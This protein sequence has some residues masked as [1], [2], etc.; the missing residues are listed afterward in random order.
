MKEGVVIWWSLR[1]SPTKF[2]SP[3]MHYTKLTLQG[4]FRR[5]DSNKNKNQEPSHS[6]IQ[7]SNLINVSAITEYAV[8]I[9]AP[10]SCPMSCHAWNNP[11]IVCRNTTTITTTAS[12]THWSNTLSRTAHTDRHTHAYRIPMSRCFWSTLFCRSRKEAMTSDDLSFKL[13]PC[14]QRISRHHLT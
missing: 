1:S 12:C 4:S 3:L 6:D 11:F 7:S 5:G 10:H 9:E 13:S 8:F 2:V 14:T